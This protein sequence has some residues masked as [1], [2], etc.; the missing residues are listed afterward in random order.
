MKAIEKLKPGAGQQTHILAAALIWTAVGTG[1]LVF[2]ARPL[3][4][5]YGY[6]MLAAALL[7]GTLKGYFVLQRSAGKNIVRIRAF[8]QV[9][10]LGAV[11]SV[12]M[13]IMVLVMAG[14]GRWLRL[15]SGISPGLIGF[16]YTAVG[17]ALLFSSR[18]LWREWGKNS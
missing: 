5:E 10:C 8:K 12:K 18:L 2:G 11:F 4:A 15:S 6:P 9:T 14:S 16:L 7:V 3:L 13:W 17:W 1:L